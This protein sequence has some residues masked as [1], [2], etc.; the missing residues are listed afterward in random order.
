MEITPLY[1]LLSTLRVTP[2]RL[3]FFQYETFYTKCEPSTNSSRTWTVKRNT[4]FSKSEPCDDS[5][6]ILG[7]SSCNIRHPHKSFS[8]AYWCESKEGDR[9]NIVNII[10]TGG[11][12]ILESPALPVTEGDKVTLRCSYKTKGQ[13]KA[14]SKFPASFFKDQVFIGNVSAGEMVL[15][16]VSLSDE[17]SYKCKH[18]SKKESPESW[19]AVRARP[20]QTLTATPTPPPPPSLF[21]FMSLPNLVC[22]ILLFM[23]YTIILFVCIHVY[24]QR[25]RARADAKRR[26]SDRLPLE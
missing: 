26:D 3:Q 20:P 1:L 18:P 4:S 9:S 16:T 15:P 22:I 10:V 6:G 5:W 17:G 2:N 12:V 21:H 25:A 13:Q 8:G 23:L 11:V 14:T 19:L 7:P 24:R